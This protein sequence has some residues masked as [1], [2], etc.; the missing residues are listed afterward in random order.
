VPFLE[1]YLV[2]TRQQKN[3]EN[4]M[5]KINAGK[6]TLNALTLRLSARVVGWI[7]PAGGRTAWRG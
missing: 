4:M 1:F 7:T 2:A 5:G 3:R 6:T